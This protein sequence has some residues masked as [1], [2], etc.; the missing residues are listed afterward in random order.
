MANAPYRVVNRWS[1][2][3][4]CSQKTNAASD[5]RFQRFR[6]DW[7]TTEPASF[8]VVKLLLCNALEALASIPAPVCFPVPLCAN[9]E[10]AS[11]FWTCEALLL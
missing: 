7:E 10:Q 9:A 1:M 4:V 3:N 11:D 6:L 8:L 5:F 2:A